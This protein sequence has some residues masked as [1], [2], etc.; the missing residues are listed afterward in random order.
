MEK[1]DVQAWPDNNP[2]N[3]SNIE[4]IFRMFAETAMSPKPY[5]KI[6]LPS[7]ITTRLP[8]EDMEILNV[9]SRRLGATRGNVAS[10]ILK[11]GL[12]EAATGCG[13]NLDEKGLISDDQKTWDLT[14]RKMGIKFTS[15]DD[16]EDE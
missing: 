14:Q 15:G 10:H 8:P 11:F 1:K 16:G 13:F 2:E 12:Y 5:K 6:N 3:G 7:S 9:I 4:R